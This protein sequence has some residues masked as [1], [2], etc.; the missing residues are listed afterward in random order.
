MNTDGLD[1]ERIQARRGGGEARFTHLEFPRIDR[2]PIKAIASGDTVVFR[3]HYAAKVKI[4]Q[5]IWTP[6]SRVAA[7]GDCGCRDATACT[8]SSL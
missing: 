1:F 6:F 2:T 4:E 8:C 5:P 7:V 3:L